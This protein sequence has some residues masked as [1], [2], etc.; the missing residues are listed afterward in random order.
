MSS[1]RDTF[2]SEVV[3]AMETALDGVEALTDGSVDTIVDALIQAVEAELD[4]LKQH[5]TGDRLAMVS[6]LSVA[7]IID[8]HVADMRKE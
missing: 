2:R 8:K 1:L 7:N 5:I 3:L 4:G 6:T